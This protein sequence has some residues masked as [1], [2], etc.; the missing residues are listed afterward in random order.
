[1]PNNLTKHFAT[2]SQNET[3][4]NY[5]NQ[6]MPVH[7][8]RERIPTGMQQGQIRNS[9][10]AVRPPAESLSCGQNLNHVSQPPI[11]ID[12]HRTRSAGVNRTQN[13][14]NHLRHNVIQKPATAIRNLRSLNS[15]SQSHGTITASAYKD[16]RNGNIRW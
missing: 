1:M 15:F 7:F 2:S 4:Q 8:Q 5:L 6:T 14:K 12:N 13:I 16:L 3:I 10:Y 11:M 9:G